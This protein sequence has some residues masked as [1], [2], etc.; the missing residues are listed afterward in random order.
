MGVV[1]ADKEIPTC[2]EKRHVSDH[3]WVLCRFY[4]S[5]PPILFFFLKKNIYIQNILYMNAFV[6]CFD[7]WLEPGTVSCSRKYYIMAK[8]NDNISGNVF[9]REVGSHHRTQRS[10]LFEMNILNY[11]VCMC[12]YMH[13]LGNFLLR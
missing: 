1:V 11:I 10:S 3:I 4:S 5:L 9:Q 7:G 6:F 8:H 13:T 12:V 2:N